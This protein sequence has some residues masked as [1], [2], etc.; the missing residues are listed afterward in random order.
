M[1]IKQCRMI[2]V[3]TLIILLCLSVN[4][5][6]KSLAQIDESKSISDSNE[7]CV[8]LPI[9]KVIGCVDEAGE[10]ISAQS[11]DLL[12]DE[13]F[14]IG[15]TIN[16]QILIVKNN[17]VEK[18]IPIPEHIGIG[19]ILVKDNC[20]YVLDNLRN[21]ED[22]KILY[23]LSLD[24]RISEEIAIPL[25]EMTALYVKSKNGAVL[26]KI[27]RHIE[28]IRTNKDNDIVFVYSN[29]EGYK[30]NKNSV[31]IKENE[32]HIKCLDD[33]NVL[34]Q[35]NKTELDTNN[36]IP[37]EIDIDGKT[38]KTKAYNEI[39]GCEIIKNDDKETY[40]L[41]YEAMKNGNVDYI[42]KKFNMAGEEDGYIKIDNKDY[43]RINDKFKV[44]DKGEIYIAST[45]ASFFEI[46]KVELNKG[47]INEIPKI[48]K[49]ILKDD[50]DKTSAT[51]KFPVSTNVTLHHVYREDISGYAL[52]YINHDWYFKLDNKNGPT[53]TLIG[54]LPSWI[55]ALTSDQWVTGIPY[56]W[57]G[58][59]TLDYY[60]SKIEDSWQAGNV[61]TS[62][63]YK[64][65]TAGVDCSGFVWNCYEYDVRPDN[66]Y[67]KI[68][69][70]FSELESTSDLEYMDVCRVPG[71]Y[72]LYRY[73]EPSNPDKFYTYESTK[74]VK[75]GICASHRRYFSD[76]YDPYR[77]DGPI[78]YR[79]PEE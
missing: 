57:G 17:E 52:D 67:A 33:K 12:D 29:G 43:Y 75:G 76:G 73:T 28:Y 59:M 3:V 72:V 27:Y 61:N 25:N 1:M 60:D 22:E 68:E 55:S 40:I 10:R 53:G 19:S 47:Y 11:F 56:C 4:Y 48:T 70:A 16:H 39:T 64:S 38:L 74:A 30:L 46:K 65:G 71:H 23:K 34:N 49:E 35:S 18:S 2:G 44:T 78:E 8:S 6:T 26:D 69:D 7:T 62:G 63:Y 77:Y 41:C 42:L 54:T 9:G 36:I 24:G 50:F 79:N 31:F 21:L 20:I 37:Y 58:C 5:N 45:T 32:T 14:V 13:T 51:E 66:G 15:D